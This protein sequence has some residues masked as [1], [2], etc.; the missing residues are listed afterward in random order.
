MTPDTAAQVGTSIS[1]LLGVVTF[2]FGVRVYKRQMNAQLFVEYT[3][4]FE[5]I[6]KSFPENSWTARLNAANLPDPSEALSLSVLKHL[7]LCSEE[8]YLFKRRYLSADVWR[9]WEG[10]IKRTLA[11]PLFVREWRTLKTEFASYP[12]FRSFVEK[13]IQ[14]VEK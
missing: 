10:E 7:N 6:M 4:R 12:E 1:I 13:A 14:T 2:V 8:F 5:E 11:T 9:I 3:G